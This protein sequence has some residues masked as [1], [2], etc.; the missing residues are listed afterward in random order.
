LI[1]IDEPKVIL[2][3]RQEDLSLVESVLPEAIAEY[4]SKSKKNVNATIDKSV[5]LPP[6][7][8]KATN[9][10]ETW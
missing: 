3:C 2:V 10:L 5:F 6:G 7:A 9:Q 4:K 1:K 8:D